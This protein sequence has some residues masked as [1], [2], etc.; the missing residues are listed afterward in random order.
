MPEAIT[1]VDEGATWRER[2]GEPVFLEGG[3]SRLPQPGESLAKDEVTR[4]R[5]MS[6]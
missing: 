4:G 2:P 3:P 1:A 5:V 6:P